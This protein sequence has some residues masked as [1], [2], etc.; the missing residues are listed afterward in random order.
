MADI[1]TLAI[2]GIIAIVSSITTYLVNHYLKIREQTIIRDFEIREKGREFFHQ[3][4]GIVTSLSDMVTPFSEKDNIENGMILTENG[5]E[6]LPRQEI[7]R[8]YKKAYSKYAK[9]WY[10]SRENGLEIFL[11]KEFVKI[12]NGFWGYAVYFNEKDDWVNDQENI[13]K[14]KAISIRYCDEMD[15]LMGLCEKKSRV[16][17]WLNPKRWFT[18]MR[19]GI[20]D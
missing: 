17:K 9:M 18:I 14:F 1:D 19:G 10:A 11:T 16:P 2:G 4:Y 20:I 3:T 7:V 8:R 5:Y 6:E 13:K 12:L 15:K